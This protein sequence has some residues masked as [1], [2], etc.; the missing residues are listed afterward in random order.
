MHFVW[1]SD[2]HNLIE[3]ALNSWH[4]LPRFLLG[5]SMGGAISLLAAQQRPSFW[6]RGG[7]IVSGTAIIGDP[8]VEKYEWLAEYINHVVPKYPV[9]GVTLDRNGLSTVA[10]EVEQYETDPLI[11]HGWLRVGWGYQMGQA[12]HTLRIWTR[13]TKTNALDAS[14]EDCSDLLEALQ[15]TG[16]QIDFPFLMLHG[17][18][19]TLCLPEGSTKFFE[20]CC[21]GPNKRSSNYPQELKLYTGMRHEIFK[22][23]N[24]EVCDLILVIS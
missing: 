9:L 4:N 23:A 11:Y 14:I 5:H 7:V 2:M 22:E 3:R 6:Q 18:D 1:L 13:E 16:H 10:Y 21:Q 19:D 12:M 15:R 17:E 8:N 20:H 24:R